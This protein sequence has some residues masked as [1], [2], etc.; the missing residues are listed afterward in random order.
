MI[1]L[2]GNFTANPLEILR[3]ALQ[4]VVDRYDYVIID[5]LEFG[6]GHEERSASRLAT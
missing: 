1:A 3:A 5:A 2:S 4:P 6:H